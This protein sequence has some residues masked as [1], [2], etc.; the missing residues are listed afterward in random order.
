MKKNP[1]IGK[2]V[3]HHNY[4]ED[5][6]EGYYLIDEKGVKYTL[7][8]NK[9]FAEHSNYSLKD[10]VNYIENDIWILVDQEKAKQ[11]LGMIPEHNL[12]LVL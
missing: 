11:I 9:I 4:R 8:R 6:I 12:I 5:Q 3:K 7:Y 10:I 2:I 1:Y